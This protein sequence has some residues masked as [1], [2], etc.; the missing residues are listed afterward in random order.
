[1]HAWGA[2]E[3][4]PDA[5]PGGG[6]RGVGAVESPS[7]TRLVSLPALAGDP[8]VRTGGGHDVG[9]LKIC[10]GSEAALQAPRPRIDEG[11]GR[12]RHE[13]ASDLERVVASDAVVRAHLDASLGEGGG[14]RAQR[15]GQLDAT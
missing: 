2:R 14:G 15:T 11:G 1:R 4:E 9:S 5:D 12:R 8:I 10:P 6:K 7:H 3:R 13:R